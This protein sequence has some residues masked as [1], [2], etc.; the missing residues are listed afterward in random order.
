MSV[1]ANSDD[2]D[3]LISSSDVVVS[4]DEGQIVS[5]LSSFKS[6]PFEHCGW[7]KVAKTPSNGRLSLISQAKWQGSLSQSKGSI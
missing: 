2:D 7:L 5:A 3:D 4:S 6:V 1:V